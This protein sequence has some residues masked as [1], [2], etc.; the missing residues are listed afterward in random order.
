MFLAILL[1]MFSLSFRVQKN[2]FEM[3]SLPG[4]VMEQLILD[5]IAKQV[6]EKKVIRSS[7]HGFTKGKSC[8]TNLIA[9]YDG[10]TS[11]IDE[12]RAVDV[13]YL[14]FCKALSP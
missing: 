11:W 4:K 3:R 14:D 1:Q 13:V 2:H 7:Q 10:M 5:V 9:F 8:L 6:E 12:G